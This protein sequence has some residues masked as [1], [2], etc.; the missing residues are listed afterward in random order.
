MLYF[1][2]LKLRKINLHKPNKYLSGQAGDGFHHTVL[3]DVQTEVFR[4]AA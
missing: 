1:I 4:F 2:T 3:V